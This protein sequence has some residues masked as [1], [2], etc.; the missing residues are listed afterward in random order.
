[1]LATYKKTHMVKDS[2]G[3]EKPEAGETLLDMDF[4]PNLHEDEFDRAMQEA[5]DSEVACQVARALARK[6]GIITIYIDGV[7]QWIER[8]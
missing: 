5:S 1:M 7:P 3:N 6:H 4:G 8:A 2:Y